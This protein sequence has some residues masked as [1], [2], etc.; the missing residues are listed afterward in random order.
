MMHRDEEHLDAVDAKLVGN[1][2]H[3]MLPETCSQLIRG[4]EILC[5]RKKEIGCSVFKHLKKMIDTYESRRDHDLELVHLEHVMIILER[6]EK[7]TSYS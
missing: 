5:Q 4:T 6:K 7:Q 2:S 1:R 3:F